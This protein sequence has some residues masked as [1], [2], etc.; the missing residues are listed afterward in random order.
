MPTTGIGPIDNLVKLVLTIF[1]L[2]LFVMMGG[3]L[4]KMLHRHEYAQLASTII[5]FGIALWF[6]YDPA[7][8][9]NIFH[10]IFSGAAGKL[11]GGGGG[12]GT[13]Q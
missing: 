2:F 5:L 10:Q 6:V 7:S 12:V 4:I 13:G 9:I 11:G 8:L 3:R 1:V